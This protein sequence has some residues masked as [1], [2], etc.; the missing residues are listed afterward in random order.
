MDKKCSEQITVKDGDDDVQETKFTAD[1]IKD[2][3]K[4]HKG[5]MDVYNRRV[6]ESTTKS[7]SGHCNTKD[8]TFYQFGKEDC[9]HDDVVK[10]FSVVGE[11]RWRSQKSA[12]TFG[13]F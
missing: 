6:G 9:H 10:E 8:M 13:N 3:N 4:C 5:N 7:Y 1:E 12:K 11:R 2:M